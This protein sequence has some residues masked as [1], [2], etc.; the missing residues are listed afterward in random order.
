[1]IEA[2][3]FSWQEPKNLRDR[4]G[5]TTQLVVMVDGKRTILDS[6]FQSRQLKFP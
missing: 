2:R 4:S 3:P 6:V 1:M 5:E